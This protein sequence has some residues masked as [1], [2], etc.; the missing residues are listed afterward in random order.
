MTIPRVVTPFYSPPSPTVYREFKD[1][2]LSS[3]AEIKGFR[4]SFQGQETRAI[5][6]HARRRAQAD[7]DMSKSGEVQRYGWIERKEKRRE[8]A[9]KGDR[10][11]VAADHEPA[12][13][14]EE[15]GKIVGEWRRENEK[16]GLEEKEGGRD[17]T[18]CVLNAAQ[19]RQKKLISLRRSPLLPAA[20]DSTSTSPS[21]ATQT[22]LT[23]SALNV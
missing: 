4:N 19:M 10:E 17:L 9:K 23:N 21:P 16:L 18:V 13:T 5:I 12:L 6:D 22:S 20:K 14:D 15:V 11:D 1:G 2:L 7:G 3:Q 8:N